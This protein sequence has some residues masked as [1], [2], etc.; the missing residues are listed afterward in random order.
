MKN[1]N[2]ELLFFV[3]LVTALMLRLFGI[4][5]GLPYLYHA[6]EPIVVNHALAYG[7][8]DLNPHFF[9]IP[10]LV[11]YVL[12]VLYGIFFLAGKVAGLF[13]SIREFETSFYADP[14]AFYLIARI[15]LGAV[16]G[17]LTVW[18]FSHL[19]RRHFDRSLALMGAFFLTV[20]FI[21]VRDSHYVYA[22]IPL[23]LVIVLTFGALFN[24]AD[25]SGSLKRHLGV[26]A[27]IGL[28][29]AVKYNGCF[30]VVPYLF[31]C[32]VFSGSL[33]GLW[34]RS[35][36]FP[37]RRESILDPRLR[38]SGMTGEQS[39]KETQWAQAIIRCLSP[40]TYLM[41]AAVAAFVV[42]A[43]LN[44]YSL[45][46]FRFFLQEMRSEAG[47]HSGT[48][49][50][51]HFRYSLAG[52]V[53]WPLLAASCLG[54]VKSFVVRDAKRLALAVFLISYYF[55]IVLG[56]QYPE[57]YVLPLVPAVLFFAAD[58]LLWYCRRFVP[59]RWLRVAVMFAAAMPTMISTLLVI[60][61]ADRP[62]TRT[63]ARAWIEQN[64]PNNSRIALD[65][66][67]F[68]PKLGFSREQL[69]EKRGQ[70]GEGGAFSGGRSRKLDYL[71]SQSGSDWHGYN[72][73]FLTTDPKVERPFFSR[74]ELAYDWD[75]LKQ[76]GIEYIVVA[77]TEPDSWQ[78][79][80][81][82][83]LPHITKL[84]EAFNPYRKGKFEFS[85]DPYA[86]TGLPFLPEDLASRQSPGPP[87]E[88]YRIEPSL[89]S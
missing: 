70:A 69:L 57:R 60:N 7:S 15:V 75:A 73:F 3:L 38:H 16:T 54:L 67:L 59:W 32:F 9:R 36:S 18:A 31:L 78:A 12:F 2:Y 14:T 30:L 72:L 86:V 25:Q 23:V 79:P 34:V 82:R 65:T 63:Q 87:V 33:L 74:P 8:G 48:G 51:H 66:D 37:R 58:F 81:F 83:E 84:V 61:L 19:I 62:D 6:D 27:L 46:D 26:G 22:D 44:P 13:A 68:M 50:L 28:A 5:F 21:H 29:T 42:Y 35:L 24:L 53:G 88:I 41:A 40:S 71:L 80:F 17:T 49:W 20:C 64:I 45:L 89:Q 55:V 47:A 56:G 1:Q 52:G 43:A 39:P 4:Q 76:K 77:K 10:P 11:S 85:L